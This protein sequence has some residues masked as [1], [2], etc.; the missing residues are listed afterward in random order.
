VTG[1][2][3]EE[4]SNEINR[5]LETQ[6]RMMQNVLTGSTG[7]HL[8]LQFDVAGCNRDQKLLFQLMKAS[9]ILSG[10]TSLGRVDPE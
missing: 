2:N 3:L 10:V 1:A 8:R 5:I 6:H 9:S 7:Q 4:I